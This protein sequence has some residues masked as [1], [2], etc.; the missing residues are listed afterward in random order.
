M[1]GANINNV[2]QERPPVGNRTR[3]TARSIN[4]SPLV[5]VVG[6]EYPSPGRGYPAQDWSTPQKGYGNQ[7]LGYPPRR[8][9]YTCKNIT[10]RRTSYADGK[11]VTS[12]GVCVVEA[13]V[14]NSPACNLTCCHPKTF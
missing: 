1:P 4:M 10:S 8:Q 11:N 14:N 2:Q 13:Q 6:G 12:P 5:V 7:R 3:H 9:T